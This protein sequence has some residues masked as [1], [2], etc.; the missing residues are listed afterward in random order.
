MLGVFGRAVGVVGWSVGR[1]VDV[2]GS[3]VW[4]G[5]EVAGR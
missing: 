2:V 5:G 1:E 4:V 3:E